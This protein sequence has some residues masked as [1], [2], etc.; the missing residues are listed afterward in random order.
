MTARILW[1]PT[2]YLAE[3]WNGIDEHLL[4]LAR[5]FDR[6]E[7]ELVVARRESDG[8]QTPDLAERA[9]LEVVDGPPHGTPFAAQVRAYLKLYR[10]S[11]ADLVHVHTP[12][13]GGESRSALAARLAGIPAVLSVHQIQPDRQRLRS[14]LVNRVT[15]EALFR[16][17]IAVSRDVRHSLATQAGLRQRKIVVV[18]NGID[19]P[20]MTG[21]ERPAVR[22]AGEVRMLCMARL[23][24]EKG[25]DILLQA[26]ALVQKQHP[27]VV[28]DIAGDGPERDRLGELARSLGLAGRVHF[29]GYVPGPAALLASAHLLV[30]TPRY[31]GFGLVIAEAMAASLPVVVTPAAGGIRDLVVDGETGAVARDMTPEAVAAAIDRLLTD[32][33]ARAHMGANGRSRWLQHFTAARMAERTAEIY[34]GLL[35]RQTV[36]A[37]MPPEPVRTK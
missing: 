37:V 3:A 22:L 30:H 11:G 31:E 33:D 15:Q 32:P 6:S 25:I 36:P 28:L 9:S 21:I 27:G 8:P 7:F 35:H 17:T 12:V 1:V 14:R 20:P 2:F 5:H 26:F 24:P 16:T 10:A 13:A 19:S 18:P 34:R 23:S 29:L 4:T